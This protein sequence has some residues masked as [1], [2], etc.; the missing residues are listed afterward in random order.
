[1]HGDGLQSRDFTFVS[2]AV[3]ANLKA[4]EAPAERAAGRAFNIAGG[5]AYTLL[6]LLATLQDHLG[7]EVA[8]HHVEPRA[9]DVR[10]SCAAVAAAERDL[11]F[12]TEVSFP[13]GLGK[14]VDWFT[15]R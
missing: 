12:R 15:R 7:T 13:E 11:G 3:A 5:T 6:D 10:H 2:D 14:T 4:L 1:V 9:G 8:P